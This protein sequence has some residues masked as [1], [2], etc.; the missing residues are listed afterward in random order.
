MVLE[1]REIK[2]GLEEM[3]AKLVPV[4]PVGMYRAGHAGGGKGDGLR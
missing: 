1:R 4:L 2:V 3:E